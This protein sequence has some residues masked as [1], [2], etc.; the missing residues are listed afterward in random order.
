MPWRSGGS[1]WISFATLVMASFLV[2]GAF[3]QYS[4]QKITE[5]FRTNQPRYR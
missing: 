5:P 3:V 1:S 2:S 4:P